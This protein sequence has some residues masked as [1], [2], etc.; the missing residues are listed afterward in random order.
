[1]ALGK[2]NSADLND[3]FLFLLGGDFKVRLK[4]RVKV[5]FYFKIKIM[6]L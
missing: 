3:V 4:L 2:L 1:M 5:K 6:N